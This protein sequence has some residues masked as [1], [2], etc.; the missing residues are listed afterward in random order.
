MSNGNIKIR[1]ATKE[2]LP[3]L[4]EVMNEYIVDFYK[5]PRPNEGALE[6]IVNHLIENPYVGMQFVA[7]TASQQLVGFSTFIF[8]V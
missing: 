2:D 6:K 5:C 7:E 4:L 3:Q 1:P 8:Y